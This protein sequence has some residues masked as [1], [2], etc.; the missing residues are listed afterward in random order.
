MLLAQSETLN[1]TSCFT[2]I[3][4]GLWET[5]SII[6]WQRPS[7]VLPTRGG[8]SKLKLHPKQRK[9]LNVNV[10]TELNFQGC[11]WHEEL[12]SDFFAWSWCVSAQG[13]FC[14]CNC[15]Y[16]HEPCRVGR[17]SSMWTKYFCF[18]HFCFCFFPL[19]LIA[20]IWDNFLLIRSPSHSVIEI[21]C[22]C[23]I[24]EVGLQWPTKCQEQESYAMS[25]IWRSN[26]ATCRLRKELHLLTVRFWHFDPLSEIIKSLRRLFSGGGKRT[27]E[28]WTL[29][30]V[31]AWLEPPCD[32]R[33]NPCYS[34]FVPRAFEFTFA[35][36]E[37]TVCS[38]SI[39]A[40]EP[41]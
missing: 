36:F 8:E 25:T 40:A 3:P 35:S 29:G 28:L 20:N 22:D 2:R 7:S 11:N 1:R 38:V 31:F 15:G 37:C 21:A 14:F 9:A 39:S 5:M 10:F 32:K 18:L 34:V 30:V 17:S 26:F 41:K 6:I 24:P 19:Y 27:S 13:L 16:G 4:F 23:C 12:A 33:K